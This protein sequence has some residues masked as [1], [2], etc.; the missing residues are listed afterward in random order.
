MRK[1]KEYLKEYFTILRRKE[2]TIL[3]ANLAYFF[4]TSTLP[5]AALLVYAA[6][7]FSLSFDIVMEFLKDT[8]SP[9][10]LNI[11]LPIVQ[12][13]TLNG[14]SIFILLITVF[15][16]SNGAHSIIVASNTVFN[17]KN[18]NYFYRIFKAFIITILIILILI[19]L[20]I[21]PIFGES[22]LK[23]FG[24]I[25]IEHEVIYAFNI[26]YPV[27]KYPISILIIFLL[28]K[29][30]YTIA[31][32]EKIKS[33]Y[34]NKGALFTTVGWLIVSFI[35]GLYI[36]NIAIK[37][38]N[39]YYGSFATIVMILLWFYLIAYIFVLGLVMNYKNMETK[40]SE[41]NKIALAEIKNKVIE[42]EEKN[43]QKE[44]KRSKIKKEGVN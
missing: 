22:I 3:P 30:V 10:L 36:N 29:M 14:A 41:T 20:L 13:S 42:M 21:V 15:V 43:F 38:F 16:A 34:V 5:I 23:L 37:T 40:I 39:L 25:G 1:I 19:F 27:L 11:M 18:R 7:S 6:T 24:F 9:A 44:V 26:L 33:A 8:V 2:I 17:I 32:D 35:Y 28:V 12:N 31:P 4:F